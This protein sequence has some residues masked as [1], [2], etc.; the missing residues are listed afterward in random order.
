MRGRVTSAPRRTLGGL[1]AAGALAAALSAGSS[2][3]AAGNDHFSCV[4]QGVTG[5]LTPPIPPPPAGSGQKGTYSFTGGATCAVVDADGEG[6]DGTFNTTVT[7]QGSYSNAACDTGF[8]AGS[9]TRFDET[10]AATDPEFPIT[11]S[12]AGGLDYEIN[13]AGGS[14]PFLAA[15]G[16]VLPTSPYGPMTGS[17]KDG[18]G[19]TLTITGDVHITPGNTGGCVT[20]A[21]TGFDVDGTL[22]MEG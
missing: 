17:F 10:P 12:P 9:D 14:G 16:Q 7:S 18:D 8:V 1:V 3:Q 2:A 5:N 22:H 6:V 4:F 20:Q 15:Q 19:E 11:T 13:F 21:V